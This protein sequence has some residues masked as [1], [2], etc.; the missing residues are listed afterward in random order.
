MTTI[1][2]HTHTASLAGEDRLLP[3]RDAAHELGICV[4]LFWR[5]NK[6][7][8]V[9]PAIYVTAKTPR[10]RRS[11]LYAAMDA[12]RAGGNAKNKRGAAL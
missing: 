3:A 5:L 8:E 12:R 1:Y 10:W 9:P 4:S 2:N 7:G 6:N 11:E